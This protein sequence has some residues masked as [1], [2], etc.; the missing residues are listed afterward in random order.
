VIGLAGAIAIDIA[1]W[2]VAVLADFSELP[3]PELPSS[4]QGETTLADLE[5][6]DM[7]SGIHRVID[8]GIIE[9][10]DQVGLMLKLL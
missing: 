6:D 7:A 4:G 10:A 2:Q 9:T 3:N 8:P 1:F 5:P